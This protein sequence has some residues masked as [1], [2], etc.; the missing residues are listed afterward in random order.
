MNVTYE[1]KDFCDYR[2]IETQILSPKHEE[3]K[4]K[5]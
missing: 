2:R 4:T 5:R 1:H 3:R